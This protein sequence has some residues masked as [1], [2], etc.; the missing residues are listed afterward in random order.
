VRIRV[1]TGARIIIRIAD[2]GPG[3]A[4]EQ[5]P[6]LCER[7]VR[8]DQRK[9]GSGLGLAIARDVVDAYGGSLDFANSEEG[10]LAVLLRLPAIP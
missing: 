6:R 3:V 10:G 1:E 5:L 7:G 2:D 8:L 9:Q 4:A